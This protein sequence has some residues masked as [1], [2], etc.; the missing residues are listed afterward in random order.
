MGRQ[1]S[2]EKLPGRIN[3]FGS[4]AI[5]LEVFVHGAK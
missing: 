5:A 1:S 2:V 4:E 3:E